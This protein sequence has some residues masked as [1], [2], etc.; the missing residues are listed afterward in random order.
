M[1]GTGQEQ[2]QKPTE[3]NNDAKSPQKAFTD[4]KSLRKKPSVPKKIYSAECVL[5]QTGEID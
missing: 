1:C 2:E 5:R 3:A 4:Q